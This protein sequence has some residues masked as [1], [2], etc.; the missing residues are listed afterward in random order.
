[1]EKQKV[2]IETSVICYLTAKPSSD[3]V[4]AGH[5]KSTY[6]WWNK[7]KSK[8]DCYISGFVFDEI[9]KGDKNASIKRL[10]I[11]KNFKY[12]EINE[13]IEKLAEKYFNLFNIP[14]KS[15]FDSL[16]LAIS[17]WYNIDFLLSWNCKH[18]ANAIVN[19]RLREY[20]YKNNLHSIILCTPDE[21]M[22]VKYE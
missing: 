14:E 1:M 10:G 6:D 15:K 8:F 11:V 12:L 4:V 13:D 7:T 3:I 5:Q 21:L 17:V 2:Y 20:N 19:Q 22:E 16:H 9:S 18:I